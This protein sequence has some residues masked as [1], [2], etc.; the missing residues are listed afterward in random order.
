MDTN[1]TFVYTATAKT[2]SLIE[3]IKICHSNFENISE[4]NS[5]ADLGVTYVKIAEQL[6]Y[7]VTSVMTL[8]Y[9]FRSV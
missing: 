8:A 6:F 7:V 5:G 1:R 9:M 4:N 2:Y 3:S